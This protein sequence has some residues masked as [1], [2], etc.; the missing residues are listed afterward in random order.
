MHGMPRRTS[1]TIGAASA[2][3]RTAEAALFLVFHAH[4]IAMGA[5]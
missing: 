5:T 4:G 3:A 2:K 1:L